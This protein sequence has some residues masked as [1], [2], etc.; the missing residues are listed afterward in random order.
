[1]TAFYL[2]STFTFLSKATYKE[3]QKQINAAEYKGSS[4]KNKLK[5]E[6]G[7]HSSVGH[8]HADRPVRAPSHP[9]KTL[10]EAFQ[11]RPKVGQT[12]V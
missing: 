8:K 1:M 2:K 9:P 12:A 11:R 6:G 7:D 10:P 5:R 3:E 4:Q